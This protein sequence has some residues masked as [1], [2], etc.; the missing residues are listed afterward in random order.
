MA[1]DPPYRLDPFR[2]IINISFKK[3][4]FECPPEGDGYPGLVVKLNPWGIGFKT[5]VIDFYMPI[6]A[7]G[8]HYSGNPLYPPEN[9]PNSPPALCQDAGETLEQAIGTDSG[10]TY[11]SAVVVIIPY[12]INPDTGGPS[13][14]WFTTAVM[15]DWDRISRQMDAVIKGTQNGESLRSNAEAAY[16]LAYDNYYD[17]L[18]QEPNGQQQPSN[19]TVNGSLTM[20]GDEPSTF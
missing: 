11:V 4:I 7:T 5:N 9:N 17:G 15:E 18:A 1:I 3:K 12:V 14:E 19:D 20:C 8:P 13:I 2:S 6:N 10:T 16:Q